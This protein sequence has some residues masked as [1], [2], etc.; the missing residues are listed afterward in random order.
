MSGTEDTRS[1]GRPE[2]RRAPGALHALGEVLAE[3]G[4][5]R[6]LLVTGP[7]RRHVSEAL[8]ALGDLPHR[9]LPGARTH[10]P[11]DAVRAAVEA[12]DR[13][14]ADTVVA[15]GGGA[16]VGLGKALRQ[17]RPALRFVAVPTTYAGSEL[18]SIWGRTDAG[19]KRTGRDPRVRPDVVIHD[20][21][22]TA[23]LPRRQ[24]IQSLANAL[25]HPVSALSVDGDGREAAVG[26]ID[27][28]WSALLGLAAEPD[29]RRARLEAFRGAAAAARV[30]DAGRLGVHHRVAHALGGRFDLP[31]AALHAM[32]LPAFIDHLSRT[33]PAAFDAVR[34]GMAVPD[35]AAALHDALARVGAPVSL[36]AAFDLPWEEVRGAL[37][38]AQLPGC[39]GWVRDAWLGHRPSARH[40]REDWGLPLPVVVSGPAPSAARRVVVA[41]HA[42]G[43]SAGQVVAEV[44]GLVGYAPDVA[45]VAP[46]APA[47]TWSPAR[48]SAPAAEHG[49]DLDASLGAFEAVLDRLADEVGPA[50]VAVYGFSQGGCFAL[51]ALARGPRPWAAVVAPS[52]ARLLP[53]DARPPVAGALR[54]PDG[55]GVPV[56]VGV[57]EGDAWVRRD[58]VDG[59]ARAL[60]EAGAD[61]EVMHAP[62]GPHAL[63]MR[64]RLRAGALL[65]ARR[66]PL[67]RGFGGPH[68]A[69]ALEGALPRRQNGPQHPPYGLYAEQVNTTGFHALRSDNVRSWT[70]RVRPSAQTTGRWTPVEHDT[71]VDDFADAPPEPNLSGWAPL[72][73]PR[74]P[75]DFV[76][77]LATLGG[78]GGPRLRRGYAVHLYAA[79]RGMDERAFFDAD[80]EL[81]LVPQQG[82]L[83]LVTDLG[84]LPVA[85]GEIAVIPRGLRFSV[86]LDDGEARG[87]VAEVFARRFALPERGPVGANGLTEA[88]HFRLPTPWF[89]DRLAPGFRITA[90][91]GGALFESRQDHSPWDVAAWHGNWA[92]YAYDLMD[93][94]PAGFTRFDHV[95]PSVYTVLSA[96]LDEHGADALDLVVFPP[97]W[98]P[99]EGTFRPPYFHR[100]VT[101][102]IN[103]IV[104]MPAH[105]DGPFQAGMTFLTPSMTPHG[106]LARGVERFL[107]LPPEAA[108]RPS[109]STEASLW[110]QFESA[111][112]LG[113]TGWARNAETRLRDWHQV[114]GEYRAH[115]DPAR[116]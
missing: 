52:A 7:S 105:A 76:D 89:E 54:R 88:R 31:H 19:E 64:Q 62:A 72:P 110:F 18:T 95:D 30:L 83:T 17:E 96:P 38:A 5:R 73:I 32:L 55:A 102:E 20:P 67:P 11:A 24:A 56:L 107:R 68:E 116:R 114:W 112:P 6:V 53:E 66:A 15:L 84:L 111:L 86:L 113:L 81:L 101:T 74:T 97:R 45:I 99:T 27:A 77:G 93:F 2:L 12:V 71:L 90:K 47:R 3:L 82:A 50:R 44:E 33:A 61:V 109:R 65:G 79:N 37:V 42:R 69:E 60:A 78:A 98:D 59:T 4:A 104:R 70:Y 26:A 49:T 48:Y 85:P 10:V 94:A 91:H 87:Y 14:Q 92:P 1:E 22:L 29:D 103:G 9:V 36:G 39:E 57:P 80:G 51:E 63:S 16:A 28:V 115:F 35:P 58:D 23:A 108:D 106:V 41:F 8:A 13:D 21:D 40:R 25:A 43:R 34:E 75:T 100:N 46:Q